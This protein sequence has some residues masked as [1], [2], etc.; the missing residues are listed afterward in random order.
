MQSH[1]HASA[2]PDRSAKHGFTLIELLTVIAI[3]GI[4]A[5]I[6]IP[7]VGS[8]R[9]KAKSL[10]CAAKLREWGKVVRLFGNDNKG[11][12]PLIINV[13]GDT[14]LQFY[15]PYFPK[16]SENTTGGSAQAA[17]YW[18][19]C[20]TIT[21][22]A[23]DD[24]QRRYYNFLSPTTGKKS[25]PANS[26][27]FGASKAIDYY[28]LGA[29]KNPSLLILMLEQLPGSDAPVVQTDLATKVKPILN[30]ADSTL[31]RHNGIIYVL[32]L[33][34]SVR[35]RRWEDLEFKPGQGV[36]LTNDPRFNL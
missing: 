17:D 33:D 27:V 9:N 31:I 3:I 30:G 26:S 2:R 21:R 23:S 8:V 16:V 5:A 34:G 28:N 36:N 12:V 6:I 4:L 7:T 32:Y 13:S 25:A 22:T 10:Q 35:P 14:A 11:N 20:P 15:N 24:T 29:A 1:P 19:L 18:S